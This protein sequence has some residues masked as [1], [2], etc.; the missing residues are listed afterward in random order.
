M[1]KVCVI[2]L[3]S[4]CHQVVWMARYLLELSLLEGQC[5]VFQPVQLAGAALCL[6]RQV[7]QEPPTPEGEAAWC[8][9]SSIH[10]GRCAP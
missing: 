7:L 1:F 4:L 3:F 6:S 9:A 8:L 10:V 2:P 5:V